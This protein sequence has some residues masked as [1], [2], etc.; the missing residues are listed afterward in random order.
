MLQRCLDEV[1][2]DNYSNAYSLY[3]ANRHERATRVQVTSR[4]IA[5]LRDGKDP[6]WLYGYDVFSVPLVAPPA[7]AIRLREYAVT[8]EAGI[9][10]AHCELQRIFKVM[11]TLGGMLRQG[12]TWN[13]SAKLNFQYRSAQNC[14]VLWQAR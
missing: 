10:P 14:V 9:A 2:I 12:R 13:G 5:W 3:E 6:F 1:G 7:L 8:G 4:S 11:R